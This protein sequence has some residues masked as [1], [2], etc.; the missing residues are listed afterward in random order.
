M[1]KTLNTAYLNKE[2]V[3]LGFKNTA[4]DVLSTI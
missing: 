1:R 3:L 4:Y 2:E